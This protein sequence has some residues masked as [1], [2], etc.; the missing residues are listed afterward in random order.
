MVFVCGGKE[1]AD[2]M[3]EDNKAMDRA[4]E[5]IAGKAPNVKIGFVKEA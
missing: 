3:T 5:A 2:V 1:Y 4:L